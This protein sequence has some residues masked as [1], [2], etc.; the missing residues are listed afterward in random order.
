[1]INLNPVWRIYLKGSGNNE[2]NE[3]IYM[4]A[5]WWDAQMSPLKLIFSRMYKTFEVP[6]RNHIFNYNLYVVIL[7]LEKKET[8]V[9]YHIKISEKPQ[10][11]TVNMLPSF[12]LSR[13]QPLSDEW[14]KELQSTA[15]P[16]DPV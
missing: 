2:A 9:S 16:P 10:D 13:Q 3:L 11:N 6:E 12:A 5:P 4:A 8:H 14:K 1:M 15:W 7:S